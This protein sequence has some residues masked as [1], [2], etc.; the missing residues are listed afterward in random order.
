MAGGS[1]VCTGRGSVV[2]PVSIPVED[3]ARL[4]RPRVVEDLPAE[5]PA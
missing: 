3:W 4:G 5:V 1:L 2:R